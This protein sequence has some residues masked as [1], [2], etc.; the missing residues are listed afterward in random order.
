MCQHVNPPVPLRYYKYLTALAWLLS[1]GLTQAQ[2]SIPETIRQSKWSYQLGVDAWDLKPSTTKDSFPGFI[3]ENSNLLLPNAFTKR[4]YSDVSTHGWLIGEAA[5]NSHTFASLKARTDQTI[6]WRID[7]AQVTTNISPSL[8]LRYGIVDYKTSWCRHYESDN[9]WMR[10]IETLCVT[11]QFRDVTGGSPGAQVF[12]NLQKGNY[13]LQSQIGIY[14][15]LLL[16]YAHR[17]FGNLVPSENYR[18]LSNQ[19]I[20]LNFNLID[21]NTALEMRISYIKGNQKAYLPETYLLGDFQQ[22]SDMVYFGV[23]MP[24]TTKITGR[25]TH[26]QQKQLASCRSEVAKFATACNL[27]LTFDKSA[28]SMEFSYRLDSNNTFS[29]GLNRTSFDI[30]QDLFT[31]NYDAF[32]SDLTYFVT[33]QTSVAWRHDWSKGVFSVLQFIHAKHLGGEA[34]VSAKSHGTALG[35]RL[36]YQY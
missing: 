26:L 29:L 23:S 1:C 25:L 18:V 21:L 15:P 7:E 5:L 30:N 6:G 8:G 31:P 2:L 24:I 12:I 14:R 16:G 11:P 28:S 17:E 22:T 35:A 32:A 9:N 27:N 20:G 4:K 3:S 34:E 36:A 33:R 13:A 19:K 10:E